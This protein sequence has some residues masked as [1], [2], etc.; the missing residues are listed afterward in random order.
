[1][2]DSGEVVAMEGEEGMA[3]IHPMEGKYSLLAVPC[4]P[5]NVVQN[6]SSI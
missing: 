5:S 4:G 6:S 1:M 2:E 3:A